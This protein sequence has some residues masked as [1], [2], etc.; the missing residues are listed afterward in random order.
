ME[1]HA[2]VPCRCTL[3]SLDA[4]IG[5]R[6]LRR[7]LPKPSA[8]AYRVE[9]SGTTLHDGIVSLLP[10]RA[11]AS[12]LHEFVAGAA[13]CA[14]CRG[15]CHA[16]EL[17]SSLGAPQPST[18]ARLH[19]AIRASFQLQPTSR[20]AP[21]HVLPEKAGTANHP[22]WRPFAATVTNPQPSSMASN[23]TPLSLTQ[24]PALNALNA[25]LTSCS[26]SRLR[27]NM[28]P[29]RYL[30][31]TCLGRDTPASCSPALSVQDLIVSLPAGLSF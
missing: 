4:L 14:A 29:A 1:P 31:D 12:L 23:T 13:Q 10:S 15:R 21:C 5:P 28:A 17:L 11:P 6:R 26:S 3:A 9:P 2:S 7:P 25:R 24:S 22:M 27:H 19:A 16:V 8:L 30:R 20:L 18:L